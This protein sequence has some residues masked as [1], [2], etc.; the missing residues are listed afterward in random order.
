MIQ[1]G[2]EAPPAIPIL[3]LYNKFI[4]QDVTYAP[5]STVSDEE[6]NIGV[7]SEEFM[8]RR[9]MNGENLDSNEVTDSYIGDFF[10]FVAFEKVNTVLLD[11][12]GWRELAYLDAAERFA[13]D[14]DALSNL[15]TNAEIKE[16]DTLVQ[17][18]LSTDIWFFVFICW[19]CICNTLRSFNC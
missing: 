16:T 12:I 15:I 17:D 14:L 5:L 18:A 8:F 9:A 3:S 4:G 7:F 2:V 10:Q 13:R 6:G 19:K 11:L 1:T